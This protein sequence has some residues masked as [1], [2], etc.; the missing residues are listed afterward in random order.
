MPS[1]KRLEV[2]FL[3]DPSNKKI[4]NALSACVKDL[5]T[6]MEAEI[7]K[8]FR[9]PGLV[10]TCDT[11]IN[12]GTD[13]FTGVYNAVYASLEATEEAGLTALKHELREEHLQQRVGL[14]GA[15]PVQRATTPIGLY[16]DAAKARKLSTIYVQGLA[17][18]SGLASPSETPLKSLVRIL[19]KALLRYDAPG[20]IDK[21]CDVVRDMIVVKT[22]ATLA[23]VVQNV[24]DD[25]A[26][27]IVRVKDRFKW[28]SSGGWR[29]IMINYYH[30]SDMTKHVCE[31][32]LVHASLLT[33]RKGLPGHAIYNVVRNACEFLERL[34]GGLQHSERIEGLRALSQSGQL[35]FAETAPL[36]M[37][38]AD[39]LHIGVTVE[40]LV[41]ASFTAGSLEMAGIN[42]KQL[43]ARAYDVSCLKELGFDASAMKEANCCPGELVEAGFDAIT[44]RKIFSID[45]AKAG[46]DMG[47]ELETLRKVGL[48]PAELR[49]AGFHNA[50]D[51]KRAGFP[52]DAAGSARMRDAGFSLRAIREA[53]FVNLC[54][55]DWKNIWP[56]PMECHDLAYLHEC[57]IC[58][59]S[60]GGY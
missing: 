32:Q 28:P 23:Q 3:A 21:I 56:L 60:R 53:G 15:T 11:A 19:E 13:T 5:L 4:T 29:D 37:N 39:L 18:K 8:R 40:E 7:T 57:R 27:T 35:L 51:Y 26:I 20:R 34:V 41:A 42:A 59:D 24:L 50:N 54:K 10:V 1:F 46:K 36:P 45:D 25:E 16:Q 6:V 43:L 22:A 14:N 49:A 2:A 38:V 48:D 52:L 44:V 31:L 30:N 33:A 17:D 58:G 12:A 55:H 9:E 47:L